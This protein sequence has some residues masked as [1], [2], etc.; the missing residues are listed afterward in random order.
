MLDFIK[1]KFPEKL[2]NRL[3]QLPTSLHFVLILTALAAAY[4]HDNCVSFY[5]NYFKD[6]R[7]RIE[8][9]GGCVVWFGGWRV[10][11]S[12]AVSRAIG[13]LEQKP[14]VSSDADI[15]QYRLEGSIYMANKNM[16][17]FI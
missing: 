15:V 6:E 16:I 13:D 8:D 14:F 17:I 10:N 3:V 2:P 12:L 5:F 1:S 7:Q 11:G 9:L 4:V